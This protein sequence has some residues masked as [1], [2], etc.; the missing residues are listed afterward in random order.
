MDEARAGVSK[1]VTEAQK[2]RAVREA[3]DQARREVREEMTNSINVQKE[4]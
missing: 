2:Q 4:Y 3:V 1:I